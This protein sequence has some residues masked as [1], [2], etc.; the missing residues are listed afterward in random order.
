[1]VN[2]IRLTKSSHRLF[3]NKVFTLV[4]LIYLVDFLVKFYSNLLKIFYFILR[5]VC[6]VVKVLFFKQH[7]GKVYSVNKV[8]TLGALT[9]FS[10][11]FREFL[12]TF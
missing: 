6:F 8:F 12:V 7:G 1:M 11:L 4:V 2:F 5:S 9:N 3:C 10:Q